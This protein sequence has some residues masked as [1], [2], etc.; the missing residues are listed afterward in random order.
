MNHYWQWLVQVITCDSVEVFKV[1]C[2]RCGTTQYCKQ[3]RT[4]KCGDKQCCDIAR[5]QLQNAVTCEDQLGC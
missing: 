1:P 2:H 5:E 4:T 3:V